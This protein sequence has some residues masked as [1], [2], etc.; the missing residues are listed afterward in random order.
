MPYNKDCLKALII[1]VSGLHQIIGC[2]NDGHTEMG[3]KTPPRKIA[4][5]LLRLPTIVADLDVGRKELMKNPS[6]RIAK[7]P[8]K[9]MGIAIQLL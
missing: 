1:Q 8:T 4:I 2:R 9:I 3:K 6:D 7:I 5:K